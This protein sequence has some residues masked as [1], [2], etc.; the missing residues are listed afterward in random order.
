MFIRVH[1]GIRG[2]LALIVLPLHLNLDLLFEGYESLAERFFIGSF[3]VDVFFLLSGYIIAKL[4]FDRLRTGKEIISFL[5]ARA[6]RILPLHYATLAVVGVMALVASYVGLQGGDS[7]GIFDLVEQLFLVHSW[8]I[9]HMAPWVTTSW[10]LSME[11]MA[12]LLAPFIIFV[13]RRFWVDSCFKKFWLALLLVGVTPFVYDLGAAI[14]LGPAGSWVGVG[15]V[16]L[17]FSAGSLFATLKDERLQVF[18]NR[19]LGVSSIDVLSLSVI[20]V[21]LATYSFSLCHPFLLYLFMAAWIYGCSFD[22]PSLT[23]KILGSKLGLFL[24]EISYSVYLIHPII[25]KFIYVFHKK[26]AEVPPFLMLFGALL[27]VFV[28][29]IGSYYFWEKPARNWI[30]KKSLSS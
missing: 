14:G 30:R 7:Y 2:V 8:P 9:F 21:Y 27:L 20:V 5:V 26:F 25:G 23:T 17:C 11:M 18:G 13:L 6:A 19:I 15:R 12:Y 28:L 3:A 16:L 10:S 29:S 1:A 24:G 22:T 4:Y